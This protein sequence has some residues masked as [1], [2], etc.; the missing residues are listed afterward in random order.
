MSKLYKFDILTT[1]PETGEVGVLYL[2]GTSTLT[3]WIYDGANWLPFSGGATPTADDISYDN[4]DSGLT[5]SN[6]QDAIDEVVTDVSGKQDTLTAGSN[7]TIDANNEISATD[8]T[9]SDATTS[10]SGLMSS[11]DK[12]KLNGIESG[13]EVNVQS[14]WNAISGDEFIKNKPT[15]PTKTSDLTNDSFILDDSIG[16]TIPTNEVPSSTALTTLGSFR[17]P[18]GGIWFIQAV[19]FF[20]ANGTGIRGVFVESEPVNSGVTIGTSSYFATNTTAG[21]S[22]TAQ[23]VHVSFILKISEAKTYYLRAR[24]TGTNAINVQSRYSYVK[25]A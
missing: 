15:I 14:D 7:I 21:I 3:P 24:Q 5:A 13:A 12:T 1:R 17:L 9:Y 10:A 8:T 25:L 4:T 18:S 22:G 23:Q 20:P 11:T 2:V 19:C 6:V 16:Q